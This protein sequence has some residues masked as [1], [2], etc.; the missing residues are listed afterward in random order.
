M[1]PSETAANRLDMIV[2][3]RHS[4]HARMWQ[5]A[6]NSIRMDDDFWRLRR[7][8]NNRVI[9]PAQYRLCEETGR[10]DNFRRASG[11]KIMDFQGMF[12]NDSDVYKWI[13][14]AAWALSS[15]LDPELEGLIDSVTEEIAAAQRPDGYLNSYFTFERADERWKNFDLHEMYCAGHLIQAA[16]AYVRVTGKTTL[17]DVARRF[18]DHICEWFGPTEKGKHFGTDGHPEIEM[19]LVELFRV[20]GDTKYLQQ[21]QYFVDVRGSGTLASGFNRNDPSYHQDHVPFRQLNQLVGHAVRAVY[22]NCGAADLVAETG[23]PA[24]YEALQRMWQNMT[25]R[26]MYLNGGLGSRYENEGFGQDYELPN[27]RAHTET[28]ASI[29]NFM[30][31]WRMLMLD[32]NARY[33]DIMELALY[34][35][36]LSG[37]SLD[38]QAYFYQNPL[39]D[40][41]SHRREKWF[42]VSCCPSNLSRLLASLPAYLYSISA[43]GIW[44]HL[45]ASNYATL[46]LQDGRE[47]KLAQRTGYPWKDEIELEVQ[48][49]GKF[50]LF[51]RLPGWCS[52]D[53]S[54]QLN[55]K[56]LSATLTKGRYIQIERDWQ[57][58]DT[59]RLILPMLIERMESH[60]FVVENQGRVA[61]MRGPVLYCV[62]GVDHPTVDVRQFVLA[63]GRQLKAEFKPDLLGGVTVLRGVVSIPSDEHDWGTRLYRLHA[64]N[65]GNQAGSDVPLM[66]VPYYAWANREAA[67]MLVWLRT[68]R[69]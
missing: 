13:E 55:G 64:E 36:I 2:D 49:A 69:D 57:V 48:S 56:P 39:L 12:F 20:T 47:V 5:P 22:L 29:A 23:E 54:I 19:A 33:A 67:P 68:K 46:T 35:S 16:V 25:A 42:T 63:D 60:P 65:A 17:L 61:L 4:P 15:R 28:C 53:W 45:Y 52:A 24:L 27:G 1:N 8:L 10:I 50:S 18:A 6:L 26:Q 14:A 11:R 40:D 41:G 21:A 32:A 66:A 38:G 37:V 9:L 43:E 31:N 7:E 58:G 51:L 59:V 34:N 44:A 62:E 3:T 30:W